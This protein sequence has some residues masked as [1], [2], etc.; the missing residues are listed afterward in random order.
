MSDSFELT[1]EITAEKSLVNSLADDIRKDGDP[2]AN[3]LEIRSTKDETKQAFG[4]HELETAIAIFKGAYY[5]GQLAAFIFEKIN[6]PKTKVS[7][8]TPYGSVEI[9][10]HEKLTEDEV[11]ALL[12]KAA[13]L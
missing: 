13:E 6:G 2:A 4:I 7:I 8:L 12:R 1:V 11:R 5:L 3:V 9:R 10:W